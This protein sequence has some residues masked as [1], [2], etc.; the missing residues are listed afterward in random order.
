[1]IVLDRVTKSYPVPVSGALENMVSAVRG[2]ARMPP[3]F[4]EVTLK[5][6]TDRRIAIF[7]PP[8]SGKSTLIRLLAGLEVADSGLIERHARLS[9]PVGY[10]RGLKPDLS[11]RQN[12]IYAARI[13]GADVAEVTG[14]VEAVLQFGSAFDEPTSRLQHKARASFCYALSYAIPFD[15][16]LIDGFIGS[17]TVE[18]RKKCAAM[19]E[20][21]ARDS[22]II[23]AAPQPRIAKTYC[24]MGA[25]I[26]DR[27]IVL[28]DNIQ[29]A[30]GMHEEMLAARPGAV[31][32]ADVEP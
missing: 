29:D 8:E 24:D 4:S 13:Y 23:M 25:V 19:L 16:Y 15:V 27:N 9:F 5:L 31:E 1:M 28:L 2:E 7:G 3:V 12:A 6:P 18:F 26:V 20:L 10:S 11:P 17:G 32:H 22:G 14:F 30:I 21:R